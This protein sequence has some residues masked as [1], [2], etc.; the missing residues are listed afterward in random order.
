MFP[1]LALR[2]SPS[3]N[4]HLILLLPLMLSFFLNLFILIGGYL[5]YNIVLVRHVFVHPLFPFYFVH[6]FLL[7]KF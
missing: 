6:G 3:C 1:A 7:P 2:E 5:L 4:V